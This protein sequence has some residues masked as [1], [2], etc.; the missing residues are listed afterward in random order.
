MSEDPKAS[1]IIHSDLPDIV[2]DYMLV[3]QYDGSL[4]VHYHDDPDAG[5]L[6]PR[7][8]ERWKKVRTLGY[9][10]QGQ[11]V[12]ETCVE[13]SRTT[14]HRAVKKIRIQDGDVKRRYER[15]LSAILKFSHD[16]YS[17]HF[18]KCLG[19][20]A[21]STKLYIT[22][23]YLAA[24]DLAT[25]VQRNG[26]LL[27]AD[28][29][30]IG[31]QILTGLA[32]MHTEG[33]AHR[34]IK[35]QNILIYRCPEND[36]P[37]SWWVKLADFGISKRSNSN[38]SMT[39]FSSGT[40]AYMAPELLGNSQMSGSVT[41]S[42]MADLWAFGVTIFY[43]LTGVLPFQNRYVT[44]KYAEDSGNRFPNGILDHSQV[45]QEGQEFVR[46]ALRPKPEERFTA[47]TAMQHSWIRALLPEVPVFSISRRPSTFSSRRSSFEALKGLTTEISNTNT[48]PFAHASSDQTPDTTRT[49]NAP[50]KVEDDAE[51]VKSSDLTTVSNTK[52]DYPL[53]VKMQD[54]LN[55]GDLS[56]K[57][58]SKAV[59]NG[60]VELVQTLLDNGI[61]PTVS[62][63]NGLGLLHL[64]TFLGRFESIK[65]LHA[66]GASLEA[67]SAHGET[68]LLIATR[69]G[70]EES[71]KLFLEMGADVETK[72]NSNLTPL[73]AAVQNGNQSMARLLVHFGAQ[74]D[75][76]PHSHQTPKQ[77]LLRGVHN[78]NNALLQDAVDNNNAAQIKLLLELG[79][80]I[81]MKHDFTDPPLIG[82][83][84]KGNEELV[85]LLIEKD[86][87]I[88]IKSRS[89]C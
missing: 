28:C 29:Q 53:P 66:C 2:R 16:K 22:M 24:G 54:I 26:S 9:G 17:K 88:E 89:G 85:R 15:E 87:D 40:F 42:Q 5:P 58:L 71:V 50:Q 64:S 43:L 79:A 55:Q 32:L 20:F 39:T 78:K 77:A 31:S 34:D 21:S 36:P 70:N 18:V 7:R 49:E 1:A 52:N 72:N 74:V 84:E 63:T 23:E 69:K 61:D 46:E 27:E 25:Y 57:L 14:T 47:K 73:S 35:P 33:F 86:A 4:T 83:V 12:L 3:T 60:E 37:G 19:W 62:S 56:W 45:C 6:A 59:A 13:G 30:H 8:V 51:P 75:A 81:N 10:G 82:A 41:D 68:P 48:Q 67:K 80:D 38:E 11:V 44:T 65:L 76:R